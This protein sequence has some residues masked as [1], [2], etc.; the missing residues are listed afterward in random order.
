M[1]AASKTVESRVSDIASRI[2][3]RD[4]TIWSDSPAEITNR[5]GWLDVADEMRSEVAAL[6]RFARQVRDEGIRHVALLGMG[7]S[8]LGAEVLRHCLGAREGWPELAVLDSTL[9]AQIVRT[10]DSIDLDR[11]LFVVSSKSGTTVEP[12]LLYRYFRSLVEKSGLGG[13]RFIAVTDP[14]SPLEELATR[15]GFRKAFLNSPDI[16]GRYSVL[17][18]FGLAP[19]A[20]AGYDIA[21]ILDSA[22]R[23]SKACSPHSAARANPGALMGASFASLAESGRDKLTI[24]TSP[25]LDSFGLWAEQIVAE[26]LGKR[27]KG[28]VPVTNEPVADAG[29]YGQ[30]RQF[31]YLKQSG[32]DSDIDCLASE[33]SHAGHPVI[34]YE[35]EDMSALGGEFYR[36]EFAVATAAAL[37]GVNPFDQPDVERAKILTKQALESRKSDTSAPMTTSGDSVA[38]LI[39]GMKPRDYLAILA[40]VSQTPE[41]DAALSRFRSDILDRYRIPTTL[42]YGPRYLHSTGQLHKGGPNNVAALMVVSPHEEDIAIPGENFTFGALSDAQADADLQALR[43]VG[44]RTARVSLDEIVTRIS[45]ERL[46]QF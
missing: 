8:S 3:E 17:S 20:L 14:G 12:N 31:V 33:L 1:S 9:P 18:Y 2:W 10:V 16:C 5:L 30:D 15:E 36:W 37:M 45:Q 22:T 6:N 4:Y 34:Q 11:A 13:E 35:I 43:D 25:A 42:G 24:L 29:S 28:I 19:A 38:E 41:H 46:G 26:S 44:R 7:G 40:Y 23:M 21:G 27:G 32:E 39:T